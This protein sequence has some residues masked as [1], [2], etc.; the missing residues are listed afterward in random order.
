MTPAT[1]RKLITRAGELAKLRFSVH[2]HML[3]HACEF[4]LASDGKYTRAIS[5]ISRPSEHHVLGA[6]Y[7]AQSGPGQRVLAGLKYSCRVAK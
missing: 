2:P 6:L 3:R 4:K 1:V 5:A 7:E